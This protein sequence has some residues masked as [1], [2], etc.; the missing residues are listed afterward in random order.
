M[1]AELRP[2]VH[3]FKAEQAELLRNVSKTLMGRR[4]SRHFER[5][6]VALMLLNLADKIDNEF[7]QTI[8]RVKVIDLLTWK[9]GPRDDGPSVA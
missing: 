1:A 4:H 2:V 8:T 7:E 6:Q 3:Q 5:N 9:A